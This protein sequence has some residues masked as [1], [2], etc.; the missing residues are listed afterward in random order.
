MVTG[1]KSG[2]NITSACAIIGQQNIIQRMSLFSLIWIKVVVLSSAIYIKFLSIIHLNSNGARKCHS[3]WR[4]IVYIRTS[5]QIQWN[6][7]A[8]CWIGSRL[9]TTVRSPQNLNSGHGKNLQPKPIPRTSSTSLKNYA[10]NN[11]ISRGNERS[12]II[13]QFSQHST[14]KIRRVT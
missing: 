2:P 4:V 12:S 7:Q 14:E 9:S 1:R 10:N 3:Q 5:S 8:S 6:L 11:R 13:V